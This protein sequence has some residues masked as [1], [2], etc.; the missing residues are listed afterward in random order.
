MFRAELIERRQDVC[1]AVDPA[2]AQTESRY[3]AAAIEKLADQP[4]R[5]QKGS[6]VGIRLYGE[7]GGLIFT[8]YSGNLDGAIREA[9]RMHKKSRQGG[10][11]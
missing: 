9:L 10:G 4:Y 1:P 6:L 11:R 3:A 7:D 8:A 2:L 5:L